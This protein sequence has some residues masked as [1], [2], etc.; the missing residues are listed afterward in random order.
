MIIRFALRY[1]DGLLRGPEKSFTLDNPEPH[2]K[3]LTKLACQW[4]NSLDN[5]NKHKWTECYVY[6]GEKHYRIN[7]KDD[8]PG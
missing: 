6:Y 3:A 2:P 4:I 5:P 8:V 1:H 7:L